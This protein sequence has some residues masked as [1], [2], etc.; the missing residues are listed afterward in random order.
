MSNSEQQTVL[1]WVKLTSSIQFEENLI[2]KIANPEILDFLFER[3][4]LCN[5]SHIVKIV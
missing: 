2:I 4:H 5:I 3:W 1:L